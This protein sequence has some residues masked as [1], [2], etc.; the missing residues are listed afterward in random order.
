MSTNEISIDH[1][2]T[3]YLLKSFGYK[4]LH[5]V[6]SINKQRKLFNRICFVY[7]VFCGSVISLLSIAPFI[8]MHIFDMV[9]LDSINPFS[10]IGALW[11]CAFFFLT[12]KVTSALLDTRRSGNALFELDIATV[13]ELNPTNQ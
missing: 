3:M 8:I 4:E 7:L 13:Q 9:Y 10:V 2:D 5:D 12:I 11:F 1:T 6:P